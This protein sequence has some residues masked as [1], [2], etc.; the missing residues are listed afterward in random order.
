MSEPKQ[1]LVYEASHDFISRKIADAYILVPA[2][3]AALEIHG[4]ISLSESGQLLWDCLQ[5]PCT[6]EALIGAILQEYEVDRETAALDVRA[7]LK[8]M[9]EVGVLKRTGDDK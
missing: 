7:F 6:E 4:M 3:A 2:G 8:K 5:E 9:D 1:E